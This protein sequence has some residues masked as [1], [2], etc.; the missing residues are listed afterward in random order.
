MYVAKQ[1]VRIAYHIKSGSIGVIRWG[2]GGM[3]GWGDGDP[4]LTPPWRGE[5]FGNR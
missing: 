4:P 3:G 1:S 5:I 2:D